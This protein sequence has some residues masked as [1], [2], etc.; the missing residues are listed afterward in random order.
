M[1]WAIRTSWKVNYYNIFFLYLLF[2][3][4]LIFILIRNG[5]VT[6]SCERYNNEIFFQYTSFNNPGYSLNFIN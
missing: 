1:F 3:R 5:N 4:Y 6:V 2:E